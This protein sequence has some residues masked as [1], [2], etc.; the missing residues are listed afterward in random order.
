[1]TIKKLLTGIVLLLAL[2]W[3][4]GELLLMSDERATANERASAVATAEVRGVST[5]TVEIVSSTTAQKNIPTSTPVAASPVSLVASL[6]PT[7]AEI[8][9]AG[10][11]IISASLAVDGKTFAYQLPKGESV[12]TLLSLAQ[13]RGDLY[14]TGKDYSGLGMLVVGINGKENNKDKNNLY[15]IYSVNGHK[16]TKGV[17]Q[18]V[19]SSGDIVSWSYEQ[20]TY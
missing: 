20:N 15:W 2:M 18:Y 11:E 19:L 10:K 13:E 5:S 9:I 16:A 14:F 4:G 3:L 17:S 1:M 6:L 12:A 8:P 7:Q